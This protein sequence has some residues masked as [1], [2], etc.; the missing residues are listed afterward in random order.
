MK[1]GEI[2]I[3]FFQENV[4][5]FASMMVM[6]VYWFVLNFRSVN[7]NIKSIDKKRADKGMTPMTEEERE[8]LRGELRSSVINDSL[9]ALVS[10]IVAMVVTYFMLGVF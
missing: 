4:E 3:E 6:A 1:C 8:I 5:A 2:M 9:V 7:S 10:G